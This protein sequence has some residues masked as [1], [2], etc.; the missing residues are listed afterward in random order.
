MQTA[1][2]RFLNQYKDAEWERED[3]RRKQDEEEVFPET[4]DAGEC[5][6]GDRNTEG[7]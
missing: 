3:K 6:A 2:A 5:T 7:Y 4:S 1:S